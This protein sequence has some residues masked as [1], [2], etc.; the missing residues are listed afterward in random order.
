MSELEQYISSGI[1][2]LYVAGSLSEQENREVASMCNKHP[3]V[4]QEVIRIEQALRVLTASLSPGVSGDS[5]IILPVQT[6]TRPLWPTYFGWIAASIAIVGLVFMFNQKNDLETQLTNSQEIQQHLETELE[7]ATQNRLAIQNILDALRDKNVQKIELP[8]QG[9]FSDAY[10]AVYWNETKQKLYV[11]LN[12][13]PTPPKGKQYQLW[14]LKLSPL[15]PTSLGVIDT[16]TL[17]LNVYEVNNPNQS[18]AFGITLE[19]TGGSAS[20]NLEQLYVLGAVTP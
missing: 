14:S 20:P 5:A 15:T 11:D 19:P 8:G 4:A 10:A 2:E 16:K 17:N 3:E 9:Q 18:E 1:L 13:L 6:V 12:G 7:S